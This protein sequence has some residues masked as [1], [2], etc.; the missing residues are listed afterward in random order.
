MANP[1]IQHGQQQ[2]KA[3]TAIFALVHDETKYGYT[4]L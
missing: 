1:I 4:V 2:Q 3:I